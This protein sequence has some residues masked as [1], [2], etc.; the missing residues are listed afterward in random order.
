MQQECHVMGSETMNDLQSAQPL[1]LLDKQSSSLAGTQS[2][3]LFGDHPFYIKHPQD[4]FGHQNLNWHPP[5]R[6]WRPP[7]CSFVWKYTETSPRHFVFWRASI[8]I[9]AAEIVLG[10]GLYRKGGTPKKGGTLA[11]PHSRNSCR[12]DSLEGERGLWEGGITQ[13]ATPIISD[14]SH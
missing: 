7:I 8:Y 1:H 11:S 14:K 13:N 5:K 6:D 3:T 10:G 4:N 9:L 12:N 2:T